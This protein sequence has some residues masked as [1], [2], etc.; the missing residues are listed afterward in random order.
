MGS[1][2]G[3]F[4]VDA[5]AQAVAYASVPEVAALAAHGE[6]GG[7]EQVEGELDAILV[8]IRDFWTQEPDQVMA[9]IAAIT[10]RLTE[11]EVLLHRVEAR[12]RR[13][14]QIRTMQVQKIL[15]ECDRQF[16]IASRLVEVR[17]QDIESIRGMA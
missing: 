5:T 17:R 10:S 1:V 2:S 8:T 15:D 3:G 16:K 14:K 9:H 4:V 7:R 11:L 6:L 12:D 13:Y